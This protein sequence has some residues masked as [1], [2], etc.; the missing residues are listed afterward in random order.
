M[1]ES[2]F[3]GKTVMEEMVMNAAM[4]AAMATE[5]TEAEM[6]AATENTRPNI[7]PQYLVLVFLL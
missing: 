5:V 6:A 7:V 4:V 3:Q 2:N 1:L